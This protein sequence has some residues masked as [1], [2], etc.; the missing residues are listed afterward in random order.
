MGYGAI[1]RDNVLR[2]DLHFR[3]GFQVDNMSFGFV[4]FKISH[5]FVIDN[6]VTY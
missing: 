6:F 1:D 4:L 5:G 3:P 2:P